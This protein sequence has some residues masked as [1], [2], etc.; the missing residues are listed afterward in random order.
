MKNFSYQNPVKIIFGK[1]TI[2]EISKEIPAKSKV[3]IIYGG[4]SIKQ[5]GVYDQT[6]KALAN[7]EVH[8]FSGIE[9]N[10]HYETC[11]KAV[12]LIKEK[13]ITYILAVGGGSVIDATKFIVAAACYEGEDPWN[14]LAK[15]EKVK[16]ALPYGTILTLS[17]TGSEMNSGAVI[18]RVSSEEKLA[19]HSAKVFPQF[20]VLDP[21]VTYTLPARQIG[22]GV[23]DAF[24]HV[25]E[26]YLV[27]SDEDTN[28]QDY[29]AESLLKLL[30]EEGPKALRDPQD[31]NARANLMWASS[32]ALNGWIACGTDEDWA[33]HMIGHELTA[34]YGLD[35]AQTLAIILPGVMT[36]LKEQKA[37]KIIRLGKNVFGITT[38]NE[39]EII[40]RT[41]RDVERFFES[42]G[43]KT[44]LSDYNLGKEAIDRVRDRLNSRK[45]KLGEYQNIT[46]DVA[47]QILGIRL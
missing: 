17:A 8:E 19:F 4:G 43:V 10:P 35:H 21:E 30:I 38:H 22:N 5:N 40:D 9:P 12:E 25:M 32:W 24:V 42:L 41:V 37:K 39:K 14:I 33:T 29:W 23:V 36:V 31:Y 11:M 45:W 3:L 34:F 13:G 1:D 44:R 27:A 46:G 20:S 47:A 15:N 2:K 7:F 18:T 16:K 26:Q 6:I 28:M